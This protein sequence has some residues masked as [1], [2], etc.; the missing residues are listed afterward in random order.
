MTLV[1]I[2]INES[3]FCF[4]KCKSKFYANVQAHVA[5]QDIQYICM[6][7]QSMQVHTDHM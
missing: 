7:I 6:Y 3:R 5:R 4:A 2:S 1:F